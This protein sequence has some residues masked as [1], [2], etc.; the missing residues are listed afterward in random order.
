M[1]TLTGVSVEEYLAR[2]FSPDCDYIDGEVRERNVGEFDH[3][4]RQTTL[5]AWFWTRRKEFRIRPL[6]EQRLAV[7]NRRYRIPDLMVLRA[8]QPIS[9]VIQTAPLICVEILSADDTVRS[10]RER[11]DDYLALGVPHVWVIDPVRR[12]A[13]VATERGE[14]EPE[15]GILRTENPGM[16]LSLDEL[17][18]LLD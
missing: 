12:K 17:F 10:L 4:N 18:E 3:N 15:D 9:P 14:M 2:S 1:A 8:D 11:L 16:A 6:T 5:A 7:G 13:W